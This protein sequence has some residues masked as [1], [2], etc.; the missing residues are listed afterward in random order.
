MPPDLDP[1]DHSALLRRIERD[2]I[3]GDDQALELEFEDRALAATAGSGNSAIDAGANRT[4]RQHGLRGLFRIQAESV[5]LQDRVA[6]SRRQV[7]ILFGGR[8]AAGKGGVI[9]RITQRLNPRVCRVVALPAR[10][11]NADCIR[12]PVG[13]SMIVQEQF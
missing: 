10:V 3:D 4:V 12:Q 6:H 7:V 13:A 5:K 2:L 8:G 1:E 9:Q 11:R